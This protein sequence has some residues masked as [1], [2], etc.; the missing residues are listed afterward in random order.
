MLGDVER[1][2]LENGA[3]CIRRGAEGSDLLQ[4]VSGGHL[5]R[6]MA[7]A[8]V[9][10]LE[11]DVGDVLGGDD[12]PVNDCAVA[13]GDAARARKRE[14]AKMQARTGPQTKGEELEAK[15]RSKGHVS[16]PAPR[17]L[18]HSVE[19]T[20]VRVGGERERGLGRR[21]SSGKRRAH[22]AEVDGVSVGKP[23]RICYDAGPPGPG[24]HEARRV[25]PKLQ[26]RL[27]ADAEW[28]S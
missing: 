16:L 18:C 17:E 4:Q 2:V 27:E 13:D 19:S 3:E 5:A 12:A 23:L 9:P 6:V 22:E 28:R 21:K 15:L 14:T 1:D 20:H 8:L 24:D 7:V 26:N 25:V 11:E 10:L